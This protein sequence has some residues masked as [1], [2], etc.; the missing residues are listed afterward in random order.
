MHLIKGEFYDI[1]G[2]G[3][4]TGCIGSERTPKVHA[5]K[6]KNL[7]PAFST[8][9]LQ[10]QD[11]IIQRCIDAFVDKIS[12][13][14]G[15]TGLDVVEWYEMLAFDILGEMAFGESF[16]CIER[17][18]LGEEVAGWFMTTDPPLPGLRGTSFLDQTYPRPPSRDHVG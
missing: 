5:Q 4:K 2:A 18:K 16:H 3:F 13:L 12:T 11:G 7:T 14:S 9:A 8:K 10:A 1:Y 15:Q 6:K 17:G